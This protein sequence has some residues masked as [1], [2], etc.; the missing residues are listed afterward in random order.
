MAGLAC[1]GFLHWQ[2]A[3]GMLICFYALSIESYLATYTL[4]RFHL[5]HGLF[6]PTE[7]RILLAIGNALLTVHPYVQI[8][9]RHFHLFDVAGLVSIGGMAGMVSAAALR[10]TLTLYRVEPLK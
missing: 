5:S 1:S 7:I 10:H 4:G 8:A 6:G 9:N 3:A 2:I